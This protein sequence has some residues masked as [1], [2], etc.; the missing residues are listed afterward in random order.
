MVV[1]EVR[2]RQQRAPWYRTVRF[3]IMNAK[4]GINAATNEEVVMN[5]KCLHIMCVI[6]AVVYI[7][8]LRKIYSEVRTIRGND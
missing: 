8:P 1:R 6:S 7:D 3:Y 5:D 2:E 4:T